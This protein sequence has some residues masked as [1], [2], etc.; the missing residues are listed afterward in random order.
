MPFP[1]EFF[2]MNGVYGYKNLS[3]TMKGKSTI[4]VSEN[5]SGKTTILNALNYVLKGEFSKLKNS[6]FKTIEIKLTGIEDSIILDKE[7]IKNTP[8]ELQDLITDSLSLMDVD[9]WDEHQIEDVYIAISS[10]NA[11][12]PFTLPES[13]IIRGLYNASELPMSDFL[14]TLKELKTKIE[15]TLIPHDTELAK[16]LEALSSYEVIYL[17]T[18]RRVEKSFDLNMKD[19]SRRRAMARKGRLKF[20]NQDRISYGLRD[21]EETLSAITLDIERQSSAGYRSLSATMLDDL[22][23]HE[24]RIK[25][26]DNNV[27]P[28]IEDLTRFLSRLDKPK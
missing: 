25:Q 12:A 15:N 2:K 11:F 5:G 26:A 18:Y 14:V 17:P 1:I 10:V 4:F 22:I 8:P 3:M 19:D 28:E 21:V 9:F 20:N 7:T 27:L 24:H 6:S 13:N 16:L 23:R